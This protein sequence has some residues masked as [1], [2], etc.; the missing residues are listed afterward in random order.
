[1]ALI[2]NGIYD[3]VDIDR[4]VY[5]RVPNGEQY[6]SWLILNATDGS[7]L[8][9]PAIRLEAEPTADLLPTGFCRLIL[10]IIG[11]SLTRSLEPRYGWLSL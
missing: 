4:K 3:T 2:E 6:Q 1:M 7:H 9:A 5:V 11:S 8:Y 10:M